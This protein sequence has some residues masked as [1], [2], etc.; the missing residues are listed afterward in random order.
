M[1]APPILSLSLLSTILP[2][3]A[4]ADISNPS[5]KQTSP[6]QLLCLD[7]GVCIPKAIST[8]SLDLEYHVELDIS[9]QASLAPHSGV[10]LLSRHTVFAVRMSGTGDKG[11]LRCGGK[12]T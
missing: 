7:S 5:R 10:R 3:I 4:Y 9:G 11:Q 1:I 2:T 8:P 6:P 12:I